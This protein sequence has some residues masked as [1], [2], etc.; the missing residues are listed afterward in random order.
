MQPA[1]RRATYEDLIALPEHMVGEIIDG[2]LY[3]SPRPAAPHALAASGIGSDL[4]GRFNRPPNGPDAPGGWWILDE[5]ELHFGAD[6]LVPDMAG[7]RRE[8]MPVIPNVAYFELAPD[9]VCEVVSPTTG[10]LD[11]RRKMPS[12]AR[13]GISHLWLVDPLAKTLE[14]FRLE[15][16][17]WVVWST[18]AGSEAVRAEPF[19][20]VEI[21]LT[22]WWIES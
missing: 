17:R 5:P 2:E 1:C 11:R 18:H 14:V 7:W 10:A 6:V 20:A 19:A 9:W 12:Y 4:F 13:Q 15:A 8:R 22:R 16:D 3:A 21:D